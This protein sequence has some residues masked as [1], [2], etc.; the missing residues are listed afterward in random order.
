[1]PLPQGSLLGMHVPF[2]DCDVLEGLEESRTHH[3]STIIA[4][5]VKAEQ[6]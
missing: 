5:G 3:S 6:P 2:L 4:R 1:M